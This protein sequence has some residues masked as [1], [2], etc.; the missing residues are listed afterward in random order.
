M[1]SWYWAKKQVA[2]KEGLVAEREY[3]LASLWDAMQRNDRA[4]AL[5]HKARLHEIHEELEELV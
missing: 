1:T 4:E 3:M 5:Q 2:S